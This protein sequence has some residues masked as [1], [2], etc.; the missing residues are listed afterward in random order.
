MAIFAAFLRLDNLS[1]LA[2]VVGMMLLMVERAQ[3]VL[4]SMKN[5]G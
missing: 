2:G 1:K 4:D 3:L 5:V